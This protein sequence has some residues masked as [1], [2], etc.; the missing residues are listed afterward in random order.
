MHGTLLWETNAK[1]IS[2]AGKWS[3]MQ[4]S[5]IDPAA[6]AKEFRECQAKANQ[7]Q[8]GLAGS[9]V[10]Y[11]LT[12]GELC[13]VAPAHYASQELH[14]QADLHPADRKSARVQ[15]F[16]GPAVPL[17][18][19]VRAQHLHCVAQIAAISGQ[20]TN[21]STFHSLMMSA[22]QVIGRTLFI[23]TLYKWPQNVDCFADI[24]AQADRAQSV[25]AIVRPPR[26]IVALRTRARGWAPPL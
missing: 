12:R 15:H 26:N 1:W 7:S 21:E 11:E 9:R 23:G 16:R 22:H 10:P 6:M 3:D 13:C 20:A 8:K 2:L 18:L 5:V 14:P 19:P 4:F 17:Q 24:V 25:V